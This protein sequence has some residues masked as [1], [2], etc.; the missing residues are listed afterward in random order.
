MIS[1]RRGDTAMW[2]LTKMAMLFFIAALAA[3]LLICTSVQRT[4]LC[5]EEARAI[6]GRVASALTQVLNT[7]VEDERRVLQLEQSL[8]IGGGQKA[9]YSMTLTRRDIPGKPFHAIVIKV[10]SDLD[11][12]C[13][14]GVQVTYPESFDAP[15]ATRLFLLPAANPPSG[16]ARSTKCGGTPG[17]IADDKSALE[18]LVVKPSVQNPEK[19]GPRSTFITLLKCTEKKISHNSYY[20]LQDCT[21]DDS[22]RCLSLETDSGEAGLTSNAPKKVCGFAS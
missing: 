15:G 6:G 1:M 20:Y 16:A 21:Q 8:A 5:D 9:R 17:C 19:D 2:V 10:T 13:N 3:I 14:A 7:P 11:P 4:G 12:A 18:R 22:K